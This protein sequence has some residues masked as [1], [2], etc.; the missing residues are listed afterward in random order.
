MV[1]HITKPLV[2]GDE[3]QQSPTLATIREALEAIPR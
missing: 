2:A 1:I 3:L